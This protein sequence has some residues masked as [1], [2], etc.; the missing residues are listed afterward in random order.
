MQRFLPIGFRWVGLSRAG[1]PNG[2]AKGSGFRRPLSGEVRI[3]VVY[4]KEIGNQAHERRFFLGARPV[5][6]RHAPGRFDHRDPRVDIDRFLDR[7]GEAHRIG[8]GRFQLLGV[9]PQIRGF[10]ASQT[11]PGSDDLLDPRDFDPG[12]VVVGSGDAHEQRGERKARVGI[13]KRL[14]RRGEEGFQESIKHEVDIGGR[15]RLANRV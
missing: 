2:W 14:R 15:G 13:G 6:Q 12:V 5:R 4:A 3:A 11:E 10:T 7:L 1:V 9:L 8:R